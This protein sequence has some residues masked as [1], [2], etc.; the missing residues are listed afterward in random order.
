MLTLF[1]NNDEYKF[2]NFCKQEG[3][4]GMAGVVDFWANRGGMDKEFAEKC[5]INIAH[6]ALGIIRVINPY[7]FMESLVDKLCPYPHIGY[8]LDM[9]YFDRVIIFCI[10]EIAITKVVDIP[11]YSEWLENTKK[12]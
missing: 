9:E 5:K 10:T 7:H 3:S 4:G 11:G 1:L 6:Y 12:E 2:I 8:A